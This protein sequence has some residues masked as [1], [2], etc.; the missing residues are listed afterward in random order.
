MTGSEKKD[1]N[2]FKNYILLAV[3][4]L[5]CCGV[6]LYLC[7]LYTVYREYEREIPVIRDSLL[8]ITYD[9]LEHYVMDNP[10]SV[11]YMCTASDDKCRSYEKDFMELDE[12]V[13]NFNSKYKSKRE[14][15]TNYPAFVIFEDGKVVEMLQ[16]KKNAGLSISRTKNFLELNGVS[17]EE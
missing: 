4:F 6:T 9:D 2:I 7:R 17:E 16:G 13:N 12:F 15:T 10:S 5:I 3:I 11:I 14:L 1:K 8:E